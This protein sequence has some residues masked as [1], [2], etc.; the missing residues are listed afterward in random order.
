MRGLFVV[1]GAGAPLNHLPGLWHPEDV[2]RFAVRHGLTFEGRAL[3]RE[4]YAALASR[5][6][7][8]LL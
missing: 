7:E 1:S 4:E 2:H 6:R 8:A 3:S 5:V